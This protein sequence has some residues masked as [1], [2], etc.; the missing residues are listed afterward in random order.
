[1]DNQLKKSRHPFHPHSVIKIL[2]FGSL[3]LAGFVL[4]L[5]AISDNLAKIGILFQKKTWEP[6]KK[7]IATPYNIF[8][9]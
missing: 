4:S 1:L 6:E 9:V 8:P 3:Q 5:Q 2:Q 7:N